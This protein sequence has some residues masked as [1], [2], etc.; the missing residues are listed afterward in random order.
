MGQV[1]ASLVQT[2][3]ADTGIEA[4]AEIECV[5]RWIAGS[6]SSAWWS[7]P[8]VMAADLVSAHA[9]ATMLDA[10]AADLSEVSL[11]VGGRAQ[12]QYPWNEFSKFHRTREVRITAL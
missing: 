1:V 9:Q 11:R 3:A 2:L 6:A 7:Q 8:L 10:M 5:R 4:R 12:L